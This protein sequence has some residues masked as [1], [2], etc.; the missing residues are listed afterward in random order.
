MKLA[1]PMLAA[2]VLAAGTA[3][4]ARA[5]GSCYYS[6]SSSTL[7]LYDIKQKTLRIDIV[8]TDTETVLHQIFGIVHGDSDYVPYFPI[9]EYAGDIDETTEFVIYSNNGKVTG[10][11]GG[12]G[13]LLAECYA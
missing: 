5:E 11:G 6:T 8:D 12:S 7:Y 2:L 13:K 3:S 10:G 9:T 1:I 4:A